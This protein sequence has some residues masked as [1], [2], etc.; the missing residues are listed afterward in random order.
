MADNTDNCPD[1]YNPG[2]EDA[3]GDNIGDVCDDQPDLVVTNVTT[4]STAYT[5]ESINVNTT[6]RTLGGDAGGFIVRLYIS[7]DDVIT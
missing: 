3:D 6:V 2:Q 4:P 5:G 1:D 7:A